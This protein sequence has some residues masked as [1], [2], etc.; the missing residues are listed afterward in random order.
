[1]QMYLKE[2]GAFGIESSNVINYCL[3]SWMY[4]PK[5]HLYNTIGEF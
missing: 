4:H 1:M 5:A 2:H 3:T